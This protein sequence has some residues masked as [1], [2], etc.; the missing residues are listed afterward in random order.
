LDR[1]QVIVDAEEHDYDLA[2]NSGEDRP[3][4]YRRQAGPK[5]GAATRHR[6]LNNSGYH[7]DDRSDPKNHLDDEWGHHCLEFKE[8]AHFSPPSSRS[9]SAQEG[10]TL[11]GE[12][13]HLI[14]L[15]C[16]AQA[17]R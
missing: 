5:P 2:I 3:Q 15:G 12:P 8:I 9:A 11:P 13:T 6:Y 10:E 17:L 14:A 7:Q 1:P 16:R 4:D